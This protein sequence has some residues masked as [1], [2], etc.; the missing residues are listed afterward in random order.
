MEGCSTFA[1]EK[2]GKAPKLSHVE[3]FKDL[4]LIAGAISVEADGG[5]GVVLVLIGK[6]DTGTNRYLS[7]DD[8]IAPVKAFCKHVHRS[9]FAIS[10]AFSSAK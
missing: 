4:A 10:N 6:C 8:A 3:C 1:A 5:I 9:T 2:Y 7:A